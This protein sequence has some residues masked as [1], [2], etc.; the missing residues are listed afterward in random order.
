M[1]Y[2]K[3]IRKEEWKGRE[4]QI[5]VYFLKAGGLFLTYS[6]ALRMSSGMAG[7]CGIAS[8]VAR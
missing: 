4:E 5:Y 3:K 6:K 7:G 2:G 8:P 1:N